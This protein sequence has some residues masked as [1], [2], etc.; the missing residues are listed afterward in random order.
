[1]NRT[2]PMAVRLAS[3][4]LSEDHHCLIGDLEWTW[5]AM[6]DERGSVQ[7]QVWLWGTLITLVPRLLLRDLFWQHTM[8]RNYL[9]IALRQL[10]KFKAFSA[11]NVLGLALSM[12]VCLL[13][14]AMFQDY[15]SFDS[16]HP[17]AERL[18]RVTSK[19]EGDWG[20]FQV[21]TSSLMVADQLEAESDDIES[22]LRMR[23]S[24]GKLER[25]D[26]RVDHFNGL[27]AQPSFFEL[28]GYE[29]ERGNPQTALAEPFQ[30][31]I[32]RELADRFFP[33]MDPVGQ[34]VERE[35]GSYEIT[36][37]VA[38][39]EG[40]SHIRFDAL[41]SFASLPSVL[42]DQ[43]RTSTQEWNVNTSY[44]TYFRLRE[45]ATTAGVNALLADFPDRFM[46]GDEAMPTSFELQAVT[47]VNL[48]LDLSNEVGPVVSGTTITIFFI[49]AF[50]LI[51][52]AIFNYMN[53]TVSRSLRRSEELGVRKVIGAHRRQLIQQFVTES[54][55][56]S[57]LSLGLAV[58]FLQ[59]LIP[60][61]NS[62][63][64]MADEGMGISVSALDPI[65]LLKFLGFAVLVGVA[66][67][68][69]PALRVSRVSPIAA[70]KGSSGALLGGKFRG[71]KALVV[72]QFALSMVAIVTVTTLT[73]QMTHMSSADLNL[74]ESELV[75]VELSGVDHRPL[76]VA[77]GQIPGIRSVATTSDIP[78][79]N[80]TTYTDIRTP[81]MDD[82]VT[83]QRF[84][85][86]E[87]FMD[88]YGLTLVAGRGF[89]E[90]RETDATSSLLISEQALTYLGLG[91]PEEAL[92]RQLVFDEDR[93][94]GRVEIIGI[95]SDFY[96]RGYENGFVPVALTLA[97]EM[98]AYASVRLMPGNPAET[99]RAMETVW[100]DVAPGLP[101]SY[102]FYDDAI[103]AQLDQ[104]KSDLRIIG[105]FG[106]LIVVIACLGLLGMAMFSAETRLKEIGIRKT[107]GADM[108]QL[109]RLLSAEYVMLTVIALV[110]ALPVAWFMNDMVLSNFANRITIGPGLLA[111][112]SLPILALALI[113][114]GSQTIRAALSN[115]VDVMRSE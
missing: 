28:F 33:D 111:L 12:S 40:R 91:S 38:V 61:F 63:G 11:I 73:S 96:S 41:V 23:K 51:A 114:I 48:G 20:K 55:V 44:Y 70:F 68:L 101:M 107:L 102:Q 62:L 37:V 5:R 109:V 25:Q 115:P 47:D 54:I 88:Q 57:V 14:L 1:M 97:P 87:H 7:A 74:N 9:T 32:T 103:Q 67:G 19:V 45:G 100:N 13:M 106:I 16:F 17:E 6:R 69:L 105:L 29:L 43:Q 64:S 2:S 93:L 65:L 80:S 113:T 71:R 60:G 35:S 21:A 52:T 46:V 24:G 76:S 27:Y 34:I 94:E 66:A 104:K 53:L 8:F 36:G 83:I 22:V 84:A 108:G 42:G 77:W 58:V 50:I 39:P 85:V 30:M 86:D 99:L 78:A 92:G 26:G 112:G 98:A 4:I 10:N 110:I 3:H 95:V 72:F 18:Y 49:L 59:W 79:G 75:H 90:S 89:E 82:P 31:V 81:E 56:T 15:R